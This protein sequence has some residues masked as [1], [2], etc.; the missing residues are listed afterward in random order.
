MHNAVNKD[1]TTIPIINGMYRE[2]YS[3]YYY[4][5]EFYCIY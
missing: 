3:L 1:E 5:G 4:I 2:V